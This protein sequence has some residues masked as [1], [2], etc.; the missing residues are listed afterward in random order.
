MLP[1]RGRPVSTSTTRSSVPGI[2]LPTELKRASRV[3]ESRP[4]EPNCSS[5][6]PQ[7]CATRPFG[8]RC[9]KAAESSGGTAVPDKTARRIDP[10]VDAVEQ[11][12]L[13]TA[14]DV[15]RRAEQHGRF[16]FADRFDAAR[17]R[18]HRKNTGRCADRERELQRVETIEVR[19][20]RQA[21]D[22]VV[23]GQPEL[24]RG[25]PRVAEE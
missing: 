3:S 19:V 6:M 23:R 8:S 16:R 25:E 20:G 10:E 5:V 14:G 17:R 12:L 1:F 13:H 11:S 22:A 15:P 7:A 24:A 18:E 21:E 4:Q 9:S 2:A